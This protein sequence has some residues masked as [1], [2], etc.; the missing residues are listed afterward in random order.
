MKFLARAALPFGIF[1]LVFALAYHGWLLAIGELSG[2]QVVNLVFVVPI[3]IFVIWL[4]REWRRDP[5]SR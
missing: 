4:G 1:Y 2:S 5:R 3:A